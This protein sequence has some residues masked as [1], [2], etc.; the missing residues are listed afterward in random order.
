MFS[1]E[2]HIKFTRHVSDRRVNIACLQKLCNIRDIIT[3]SHVT[4]NYFQM[5]LVISSMKCVLRMLSD[6]FS[7]IIINAIFLLFEMYCLMNM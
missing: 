6:F 2:A 4:V 7:F 5:Q 1:F 3:H